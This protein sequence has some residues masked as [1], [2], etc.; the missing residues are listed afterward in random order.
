MPTLSALESVPPFAIITI[1]IALM[2][3]LQ[4]LSQHVFY[5]KPKAIN[6]DPWDRKI[7]E[8]D[9]RIKKHPA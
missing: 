1:A 8:R 3:G 2:G 5:G 7:E 9:D 4:G 6:V